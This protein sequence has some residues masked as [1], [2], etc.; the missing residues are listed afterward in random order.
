M[1][2]KANSGRSLSSAIQTGVVLS[3][4]SAY[5]EKEDTGTSQRW[6]GLSQGR[7]WGLGRLL[8]FVIGCSLKVFGP[9]IIL[10]EHLHD[11]PAFLDPHDR[12]HLVGEDAREGRQVTG[13]IGSSVHAEGLANGGSAVVRL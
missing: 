2:A 10:A 13:F 7:Q 12:R 9:E 5:F 6:A 8:T 1:P 4:V 3:L 11:A